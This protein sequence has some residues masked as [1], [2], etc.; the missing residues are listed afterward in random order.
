MYKA[1][2]IEDRNVS[3]ALNAL[4]SIVRDRG[5]LAEAE[6]RM[7]RSREAASRGPR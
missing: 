5:R 6:E 7:K 1:L 3:L 2:G 4:G